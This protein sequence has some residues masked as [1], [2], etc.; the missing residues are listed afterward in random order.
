MNIKS[1]LLIVF[2]AGALVGHS[3]APEALIPGEMVI[4]FESKAAFQ[5]FQKQP[6]PALQLVKT[7]SDY[8]AV[9]LYRFDPA[10]TNV[11]ALTN[12][13]NEQS[14]IR[15]AGQ[16]FR[17]QKRVT[18]PNDE[19]FNNQR[20]LDII[21][22]PEAWDINTSAPEELVVAVVEGADI[23]HEDL[24]DNIWRNAHE[25]PDDGIDNDNNGY[26]DDYNG[27]NVSD[28]TDNPV[29]DDHGAS[30]AGVIG[31]RGDNDI[32]VSGVLWDVKMMIISSNLTFVDIIASYDYVYQMRKRYNE[33]NGE[34]GAKV[35]V[36]NSSFGLNNAYPTTNPIFQV[37]CE[38]YDMMGSVG[39]LSAIAVTNNTVDIGAVGDMPAT[40]PSD[41]TIAVTFTSL[42][43]ELKAGRS[44]V[45][46]DLAAPGESFTT[47]LNNTYSQFEGTSAATPLVTGAIAMMFS[48]PCKN[49]Q[50]AVNNNPA[51]TA[52]QMKDIMMAN[53]DFIDDINGKVKSNGRLN[54]FATM[55]GLQTTYGGAKGELGFINLFPNPT[56]ESLFV[57]YRTS[58]ASD[59][60]L[61]VYDALGK[62][63]YYELIPKICSKNIIEIPVANMG[64]GM[65][66]I[67]IE[68]IN[69]IKSA[70]FWVY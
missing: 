17:A 62:L 57:Q 35:V 11:A 28:S 6:H 70:K 12:T 54:L 61:K 63:V 3:Q 26:I 27:V 19:F 1:T 40:C 52:L 32:G 45:Y 53:V 37:W 42:N 67:S 31:A 44:P 9:Y 47:D 5:E 59:Y 55:Q 20:D 51:Q 33:T 60:D 2:L 39:V 41:Y 10:T 66:F 23:E 29:V 58:E 36:T 65:H 56:T 43:D 34:E 13:L 8:L 50:E 25:I 22:A 68:N 24:R 49:F 69:N 18:I 14:L 30:V 21:K 15:A 16:N 46:V 64:A 7:A 48:Y 4:Q 38:A